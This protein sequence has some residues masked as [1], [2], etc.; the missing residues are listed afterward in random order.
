MC[1]LAESSRGPGPSTGNS[2]FD[3]PLPAQKQYSS[4]S[5]FNIVLHGLEEC[6]KGTPRHTRLNSDFSKVNSL[7][8]GID[9][10]SQSPPCVR[11][12][13]RLGKF[14]ASQNRPRPILVTL[15]TTAEVNNVL[16]NRSHLTSSV[17]IKPDFF[18]AERNIQSLLLKK[19]RKLLDS[20][21]DRSSIKLRKSSLYLN[22][23]LHGSVISSIFRCTSSPV[24]TAPGHGQS[25]NMS[26]QLS[27]P[28]HG[29]H[30]EVHQLSF[31]SQGQ[32][33]EA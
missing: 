12:C 29:Q 22:G 21:F 32:H 24:D 28:S 6:S 9:P 1:S 7:L 27:S 20:G 30:H 14:N 33:H 25:A 23:Q 5:K 4:S 17:Y 13:R 31:P 8:H 2:T 15:N 26:H 11:D 18:P 3:P 10:N 16:F 19:R